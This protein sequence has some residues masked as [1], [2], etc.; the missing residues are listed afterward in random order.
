[1][2]KSEIIQECKRQSELLRTPSY[3]HGCWGESERYDPTKEDLAL[4]NLL[5]EIIKEFSN[6]N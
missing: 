6:G 2:T 4:A 1:M 5:D 3:G